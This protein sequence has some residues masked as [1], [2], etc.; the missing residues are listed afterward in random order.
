METESRKSS[1][2]AA[3]DTS[4]SSSPILCILQLTLCPLSLHP[5]SSRPPAWQFQPKH[6]S[7]PICPLSLLCSCPNHF[8]LAS[9]FFYLLNSQASTWH[10]HSWASPSSSLSKRT[11]T[12]WRL[13]PPPLSPETHLYHTSHLFS[14]NLVAHTMTMTT[15]CGCERQGGTE[16]K[17]LGLGAGLWQISVPNRGLDRK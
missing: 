10:A 8:S 14:A 13:L 12:F 7:I 4:S 5:S 9:L 15:P 16:S 3:A 2:T 11:S 1:P 17:W 6:P